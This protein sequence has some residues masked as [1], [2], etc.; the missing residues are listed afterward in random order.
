MFFCFSCIL[1]GNMTHGDKD[2]ES[3]YSLEEDGK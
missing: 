2:T 1:S 3:A